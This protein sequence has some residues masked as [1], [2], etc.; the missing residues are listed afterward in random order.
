MLNMVWP[1]ISFLSNFDDLPPHS[2]TSSHAGLPFKGHFCL[3]ASAL[4]CSLCPQFPTLGYSQTSSLLPFQIFNAKSTFK[5]YLIGEVFSEHLISN[6]SICICLPPHTHL[7]AH[8]SLYLL[9][10]SLLV[11][12]VPCMIC[13][14]FSS[15]L[16]PFPYKN[17]NCKAR[18]SGLLCSL[19]YPQH[20][21]WSMD[22]NI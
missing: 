19:L 7:S 14:L 2:L 6:S 3:R 1:F 21:E 10:F 12:T 8:Y 16:S 15:P 18:N 5:S 13:I 11:T 4:G 17:L 20:L 9:N 22:H